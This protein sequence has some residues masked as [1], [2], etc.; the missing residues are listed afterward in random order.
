MQ[1]TWQFLSIALLQGSGFKE[2]EIQDDLES[3]YW[4][5]LY[6]CF[7]HYK[8]NCPRF[9]LKF[10]D[11][12]EGPEDNKPP[13]GGK[14]KYF[15]ITQSEVEEI[16][17]DCQPLNDL[18]HKLTAI[19]AKYY[20]ASAVLPRR[21]TE[22]FLS[23]HAALG[24]GTEFLNCFKSALASEEWPENDT[25][26]DQ[27]PPVSHGQAE[28]TRLKTITRALTNQF[29]DDAGTSRQQVAPGDQMDEGK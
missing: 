15:F 14:L 5:L 20:L 3:C 9:S 26:E 19:L 12:Y 4:A 16:E 13:S 23:Q 18:I 10:F 24:Q 17:W 22:D 27:M 25:L 28:R 21:K 29:N 11:E 6:I 1:G 7:H 8:H 2:H